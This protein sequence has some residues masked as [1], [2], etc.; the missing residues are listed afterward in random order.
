MTTMTKQP[1]LHHLPLLLLLSSWSYHDIKNDGK[2]G[3]FF[4]PGC[5]GLVYSFRLPNFRLPWGDNAPS[6]WSTAS[7]SSAAASAAA[8]DRKSPIRTGDGVLVFG[9]TGGVGQLV[10]RKLLERRVGGGKE[11]GKD[12]AY[13]VRVAARDANRARE[14]LLTPPVDESLE[15]GGGGARSSSTIEFFRLDLV[16]GDDGNSRSTDDEIRAAMEGAA[17]IVVSVGTTAF[18]TRRWAG[19]NTP[20]AIDSEAVG[21]IA[22]IASGV[23]SIRRMV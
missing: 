9:G 6:S 3:L 10:A 19:G 18:P 21:R 7:E 2:T 17:A 8:L 23:P 11:G 16:G 4:P 14:L 22:R 5:H 1:L 15:G 12:R 20:R 13:G